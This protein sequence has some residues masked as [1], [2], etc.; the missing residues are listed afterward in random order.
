[1]NSLSV[2]PDSRHPVVAL[3][4]E[5][6]DRVFLYDYSAQ[7]SHFGTVDIG[8]GL[9]RSGASLLSHIIVIHTSA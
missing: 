4:I 6:E 1:M 8:E 5:G 9:L 2:S 7:E 3:G